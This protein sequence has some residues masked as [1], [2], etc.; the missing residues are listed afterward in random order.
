MF[1]SDSIFFYLFFFT[2]LAF[3]CIWEMNHEAEIL[4]TRFTKSVINSKVWYQHTMYHE[5][6]YTQCF[7]SDVWIKCT[8]S[9]TAFIIYCKTQNYRVKIFPSMFFY[10]S[11]FYRHLWPTL[12]PKWG[13]M[14]P[15][16]MMISPRA[17]EVSTN[18]PKSSRGRE[19]RKGKHL[20]LG[21]VEAEEYIF[22][23]CWMVHS[24]GVGRKCYWFDFSFGLYMA[25]LPPT[26][27]TQEFSYRY[28][29]KLAVLNMNCVLWCIWYP[30]GRWRC[31]P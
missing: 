18:L 24:N 30:L 12:R 16:R 27:G 7:W 28:I 23:K 14:T 11:L 22:T 10:V 6:K 31:H 20:E 21:I 29:L 1:I 8:A 4:K 19:Y 17:C 3:S 13:L 2:R 15:P 25:H 5:R 9:D 26:S